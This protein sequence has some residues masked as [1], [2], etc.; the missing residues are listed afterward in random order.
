MLYI[1]QTSCIS[2]QQTFEPID[3]DTLRLSAENLLRAKEPVYHH[4]PPAQLRRMGKAVKLSVEAAMPLLQGRPAIDGIIIGTGNGGMDD[5][6]KFLNQIIEY[7]EG[8]LTPG[9]FVQSTGNAPAATISMLTGNKSYNITH[10]HRGQAFE[11][12]LLDAIMQTAEHPQ[13]TFLLGA[14]DEISDYNHHIEW[15]DGWYKQQPLLNKDLYAADSPGSMAGEGAAM[16]LVNGS[17]AG[18]IARCDKLQMFSSSD[19]E[20][21]AEQCRIFVQEWLKE[22]DG[23]NLFLSGENGDHRLMPFYTACESALGSSTNIARFKHMSGEYPTAS[24]FGCWLI[25]EMFQR[26]SI[27]AHMIKK[28]GRQTAGRHILL[29]N[30]YKGVQHSLMGWSLV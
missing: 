23:V 21:I 24:A 25:C 29:Y 18:A 8:M 12:A 17:A 2:P 15:L 3:I 4:V 7:D 26:R 9:N 5:S 22:G 27:P 10:V 20:W 28:A 13:K 1:H 30:N 11:N 6:I 14:V 16:F 19:P